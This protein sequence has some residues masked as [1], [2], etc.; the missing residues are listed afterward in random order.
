MSGL[1]SG[2]KS[3]FPLSQSNSIAIRL[4]RTAQG[5]IL[6]QV[7]FNPSTS[8]AS[9]IRCRAKLSDQRKFDSVNILN[10]AVLSNWVVLTRACKLRWSI[11]VDWRFKSQLKHS[12]NFRSFVAEFY[13]LGNPTI[14]MIM[15]G[16]GGI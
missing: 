5:F 1:F 10:C 3:A 9:P 8:P 12:A 11:R 14:V 2:Y 13:L 7:V 16:I 6:S 15:K 4:L